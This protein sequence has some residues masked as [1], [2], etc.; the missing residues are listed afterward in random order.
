[1]IN[2]LVRQNGNLSKEKLLRD[3]IYALDKSAIVAITDQKGNIVHVNELFTKISQYSVSE[4]VGANH[5]IINS[6]YHPATFFKDMWRT[7][8]RGAIWRGEVCNKTKAETIYWVDTTIVPLLND[9]GRPY[10]Y[11]SIRYDIT[12]KK[13][14]E[15]MIQ[16]LA[17]NDQ[18]T[19]LPNRTSFQRLSFEAVLKAKKNDEKLAL[20]TLN[21]DGFRFVNDSL[22]FEAGDYIL[23][24][25]AKRLKEV[26]Q[27]QHIIARI[28]ADEFALVLKPIN[29]AEHVEQLTKQLQKALQEP[30]DIMGEPY[31]LSISFGVAIYPEH[32]TSSSE[33]SVKSEKAISAVR[34]NGGRDYKIYEL[35]ISSR[36]LERILLENELRKGVHLEQFH[37]DYQP[38]VNLLTEEWIG[39]EALVR[40]NHPELGMIS[41]GKFIPVAEET[42]II[43]PLGEL[44]LRE[45]CRQAREWQDKGYK[46]LP[47]AV[48]MSAVQLEE[49]YI[50]NT[51]KD[52]LDETGVTT[53]LI[54]IEL[55]ESSF[56][57]K[58]C[59]RETIREIRALGITVSI[60]DFGTGYSTF[61]Y[62]KELPADTLKIDISFVRDIHKCEDSR[63]IV[64][65]IIKLAEIAGLNIIAEG[66]ECE[67]Q[68]AILKA[69]G[70][71]EAQGF[72][73]SKPISPS[74]CEQIMV[75]H[76]LN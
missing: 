41:P 67:E 16:D 6:G 34:E 57:D 25:V 12:A 58:E 37:L 71:D 31:T 36:R 50:I 49:P 30:I 54:E 42:K 15:L 55:T 35:G 62:I 4:L 32:A 40:W 75:K 18:L 22:G 43:L 1:M 11:I 13:N 47:I 14:A 45:S 59:M 44:I 68:A 28:S 61:S 52:I 19:D 38:K 3:I 69:L 10:Q 64:N 21:I 66:V 48:N 23:T 51:I 33:L 26:L 39:L 20:V 65:A 73:F 53:D 17:Y 60:D 46:P 63:A 72:Y 24:V 70:C 74:E 7:I 76:Y 2:D 5:R 27:G 56:A 8:G 29:G 9:K